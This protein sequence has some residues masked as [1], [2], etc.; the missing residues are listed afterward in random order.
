MRNSARADGVVVSADGRAWSH[1]PGRLA[2][3]GFVGRIIGWFD[4]E[5]VLGDDS[6]RGVRAPNSRSD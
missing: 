2:V 4:Y 5:E 3:R 1:R 6:R